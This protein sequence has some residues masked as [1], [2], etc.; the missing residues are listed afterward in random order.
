[1]PREFASS[2]VPRPPISSPSAI[3]WASASCTGK[4][5]QDQ[6]VGSVAMRPKQTCY[7]AGSLQEK[8]SH[9]VG[10]DNS[11]TLLPKACL[12]E[13]VYKHLH[14]CT[15]TFHSLLHPSP[16][17]LLGASQTER[18]SCSEPHRVLIIHRWQGDVGMRH[19]QLSS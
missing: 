1:M 16:P 12:Q 19:N 15:H 6:V 4:Q 18:L 7:G 2:G 14:A 3:L 11:L 17:K 10:P 8:G 9:R 13:S 5:D